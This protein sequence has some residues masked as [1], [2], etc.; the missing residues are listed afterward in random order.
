MVASSLVSDYLGERHLSVV[1]PSFNSEG[2][3][4][5]TLEYLA[6]AF[7]TS[8]FDELEVVL[9]DDGSTDQS[10]E[11][12]SMTAAKLGINLVVVQQ[13]NSG[14]HKARLAGLS[15]CNGTHVLL[16]DTR[17]FLHENSLEFVSQQFEREPEEVWTAH[18]IAETTTNPL[19]GF[20]QAIEHVAWRRYFKRPDQMKFGEDDFDYFPKGTTALIGSRKIISEAFSLFVPN[21]DDWHRANDDTAI[22]RSIAKENGISISPDYSCTYNARTT[23]REFLR[24]AHHRGAVLVDGYWVEGARFRH[25]I[26]LFL[27]GS[28]LLPVLFVCGLI[29]GPGF[30][31][32]LVSVTGVLGGMVTLAVVA[33]TLGAQ[34]HDALVLAR[35]SPLFAIWYGTGI[36]RGASLRIRSSHRRKK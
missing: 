30:A 21:I 12:A 20:W 3:I 28:V 13:Q 22:L 7:R 11:E 32:A 23:L 34:W 18:V 14:R 8:S 10:V 25:A 16:I 5:R 1:I 6:S 24:H 33:R 9:V 26:S 35:Y 15:R 27:L 31:I 4:G 36:W 19:A 2:W 29:S 17:V